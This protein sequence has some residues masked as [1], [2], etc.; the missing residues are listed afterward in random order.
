DPDRER[1]NAEARVV[2]EAE[3]QHRARHAELPEHETEAEHKCRGEGAQDERIAPTLR[4]RFDDRVDEGD[5]SAS[6]DHGAR[7]VESPRLGVAAVRHEPETEQERGSGD[8][9]VDEEDRAPAE[10]VEKNA[11]EQGS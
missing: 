6:R 2:E 4:G 5:E 9:N 7:E 3:V 8:G 10:P 1:A 11:A